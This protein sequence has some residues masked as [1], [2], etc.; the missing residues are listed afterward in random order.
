MLIKLTKD[1]T[2]NERMAAENSN[3]QYLLNFITSQIEA[4]KDSIVEIGTKTVDGT[5]W[6][7]EKWNSGKARCYGVSEQS[8]KLNQ[9]WGNGMYYGDGQAISYPFEFVETPIC[10]MQ[11][12]TYTALTILETATDGSSSQTKKPRLICVNQLSAANYKISFDVTGRWK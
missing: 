10:H 9:T 3:N 1:M 12:H 8:I 11:K 5:T 6:T 7:Y 2:E 4:I